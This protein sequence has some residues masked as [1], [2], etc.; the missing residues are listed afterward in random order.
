MKIFILVFVFLLTL[1]L[2][3]AMSVG[4][5]F[6][7]VWLFP[8]I[9]FEIG[10]LIGAVSNSLVCYAFIK[11]IFTIMT[12]PLPLINI[13]D[14]ADYDKEDGEYTYEGDQSASK[15]RSIRNVR[16]KRH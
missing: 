13:K 11:V 15:R 14:D 16:K 12:T 3:L 5:A 6:C 8:A 7:L 10:V 2:L 4:V 9:S 1:S